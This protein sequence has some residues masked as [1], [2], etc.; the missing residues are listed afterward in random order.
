LT[1][2]IDSLQETEI[3]VPSVK[4]SATDDDDQEEDDEGEEEDLNTCEPNEDPEE[5]G[6]TASDCI[7]L[8]A[9]NPNTLYFKHWVSVVTLLV[10][11]TI[12]LKLKALK[13]KVKEPQN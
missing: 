6:C 11:T 4:I 5:S 8:E 9:E 13:V 7:S 10:M 2:K 12:S 3:S 1:R